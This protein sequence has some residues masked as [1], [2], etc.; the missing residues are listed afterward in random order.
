MSVQDSAKLV[1]WPADAVPLVSVRDSQEAFESISNSVLMKGRTVSTHN[2]GKTVSKSPRTSTSKLGRGRLVPAREY[3]RFLP[4]S[5]SPARE[6]SS[7][8]TRSAAYEVQPDLFV[9]ADYNQ[10]R[11]RLQGRKNLSHPEKMPKLPA[12]ASVHQV[13]KANDPDSQGRGSPFVSEFQVLAL[14]ALAI[15]YQ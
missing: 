8:M 9:E 2:Q 11:D 15:L 4:I 12:D 10:T 5:A 14:P 1:V 3:P 13:D 6:V 7:A